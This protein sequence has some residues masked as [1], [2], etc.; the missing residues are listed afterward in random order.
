[1]L[2]RASRLHRSRNGRRRAAAGFTLVEVLVALFIM[3]ML[4][5]MA[6]QG[7]DGIV[8]ARDISQAQL[9]RSL[10]LSTVMAQWDQDLASLFDTAAVPHLSYDGDTLRMVRRVDG[11]V[12]LV[13]WT[14]Q[15]T[16]WWRWTSPVV[17]RVVELQESWLRSQQLT[18]GESG[19]LLMLDGVTDLQIQF[20]RDNAWTN[21]QSSGDVD[22][23]TAGGGT[24]Q[25]ESTLYGVRLLLAF[26]ELRLTRDV[27]LSLQQ[28]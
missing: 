22:P 10:R 1:M 11:G 19:Q 4:S 8:R 23:P 7:I 9:Q 15:G 21:P 13:A 17:T 25:R 26:G 5:A 16:Q 27:A 20:F 3:A 14:H 24:A 2:L 18:G 28:P 6:W 12:Q